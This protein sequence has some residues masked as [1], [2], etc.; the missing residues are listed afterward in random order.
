MLSPAQI[1]RAR[2]AFETESARQRPDSPLSPPGRGVGDEGFSRGRVHPSPQP[3]PL[4]GEEPA[5]SPLSLPGRGVGGEGS[6][7]IPW[8]DPLG[9]AALIGLVGQAVEAIEPQTESDVA[10]I[11]VQ[12]LVA[13]GN[14]A[15]RHR[16][17]R[18]EADLHYPN[19][20]CVLVGR[21]AKGRKGTSW[22]RVMAFLESAGAQAWSDTRVES[23]LASGE[24]LV[25]AA[26]DPIIKRPPSRSA[27]A[28]PATR[29]RSWTR[30]S[31]TNGSWSS[32]PSSPA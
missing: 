28:S 30:A 29:T 18:V 7:S 15:G 10:A 20:F 24:G 25:W 22:G 27:V 21:T 31:P 32:R 2:R 9:E 13:F 26:R 23:G 12:L 16:S 4:R 5:D 1:E 3:S 8:P 14:A 17:F 6:D 19:L 11:L